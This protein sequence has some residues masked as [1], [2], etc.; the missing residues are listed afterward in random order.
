VQNFARQPEFRMNRSLRYWLG[1]TGV[2]VYVFD[3]ALFLLCTFGS[4][5]Q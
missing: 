3:G 4:Y 2:V 5:G 1:I